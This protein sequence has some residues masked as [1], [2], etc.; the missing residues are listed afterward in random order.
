MQV[1]FSKFHES[2]DDKRNDQYVENDDKHIDDNHGK[3]NNN[4]SNNVNEYKEEKTEK[5]YKNVNKSNRKNNDGNNGNKKGKH[6]STSDQKKYSNDYYNE[7]N[8]DGEV[9]G[10][11]KVD[12]SYTVKKDYKNIDIK[13]DENDS[14]HGGAHDIL[15]RDEKNDGLMMKMVMMIMAMTMMVIKMIKVM[16]EKMA[17]RMM[18]KKKMEMMAMKKV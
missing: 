13:G 17:V 15:G 2:Y 16:I 12:N 14:K 10:G 5:V 18:T 8:P 3:N 7:D 4:E 6:K 1:I 9:N 11:N